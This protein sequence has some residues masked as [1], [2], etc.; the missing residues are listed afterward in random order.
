ML[1][2]AIGKL[3]KEYD[4][5]YKLVLDVAKE[6]REIAIEN[7]KDNEKDKNTEKSVTTAINLLAEDK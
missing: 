5:R 4:N 1:N 3:I 6:A 7:E 2:P